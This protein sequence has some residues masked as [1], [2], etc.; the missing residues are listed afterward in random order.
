MLT[1]IA[2]HRLAIGIPSDVENVSVLYSFCLSVS[3]MDDINYGTIFFI[4]GQGA[5]YGNT[6]LDNTALASEAHNANDKSKQQ[7]R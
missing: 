4:P 3:V 6:Y 2:T 5:Y 7:C 1:Y